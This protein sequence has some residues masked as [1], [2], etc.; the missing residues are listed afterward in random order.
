MVNDYN[1][2]IIFIASKYQK[3]LKIKKLMIK[4]IKE[5]NNKKLF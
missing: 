2:S 5:Q 3:Y 1:F 4:F